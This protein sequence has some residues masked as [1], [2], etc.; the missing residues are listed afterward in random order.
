VKLITSEPP[1][2]DVVVRVH[3]DRVSASFDGMP[4]LSAAIVAA[5]HR[6]SAGF[7]VSRA[8]DADGLLEVSYV[9]VE[10]YAPGPETP[11]AAP[12]LSDER[13]DASPAPSA[14]DEDGGSGE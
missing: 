5:P 3:G 7:A 14:D 9:A 2:V 11:R 1:R 8:G 10:P 12:V 6:G 4:T 13:G